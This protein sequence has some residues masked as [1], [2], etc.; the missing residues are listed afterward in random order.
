VDGKRNDLLDRR[1]PSR[2]GAH[3]APRTARVWTGQRRSRRTWPD[4]VRS[5][6][7]RSGRV[8]AEGST[9][10]GR[11]VRRGAVLGLATIAVAIAAGV[12]GWTGRWAHLGG[13]VTHHLDTVVATVLL[14]ASLAV[15]WRL[16]DEDR[17]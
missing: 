4:R 2:R 9:R 7:I 16:G 10:P 15:V 6:K 13:A 17:R 14:A 12:L 5:G 11:P 8:W 1:A 3:R